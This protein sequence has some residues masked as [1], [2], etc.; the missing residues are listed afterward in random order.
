MTEDGGSPAAAAARVLLV[1]DDEKVRSSYARALR[2]FGCVVQTAT[3]GHEALA[4][5]GQTSF[6]LIITDIRMDGMAGT[7]LLRAVRERDLDVPVILMTGNPEVRTAVEAVEAGAFRYLT[8]P[9]DL[10]VLAQAVRSAIH[11]HVLAQVLAEQVP[12]LEACRRIVRATCVGLEWDV[13]AI[14]MPMA[15]G[16]R[17][18][19]EETW[20]RPGF[21]GRAFES[22]S[23]DKRIDLAHDLSRGR[24]DR[25]SPEWIADLSPDSS[26]PR[27]RAAR[28]AGFESALIVPF[29]ADGD[30]FATVEFF[31]SRRREPELT[32]L[33]LFA[34]SGARLGARVLR[35]RADQRAARAETKR[36]SVSNTLDAI[37]E[38]APALIMSIDTEGR[39]QFINRVLD[40]AKKEDAIGADWL[41]FMP[42][43]DEAV[44]RAHLARVLATGRAESY[45][46]RVA[47]PVGG[48]LWF[49][50]HM[51][52]LRNDDRVT[53]VVLVAQDVTELKRTQAEFVAAQRFVS[54]GTVAAGVAHEVNTP[55]QFVTDSIQFLRD[56]A[57]DTVGVLQTYQELGRLVTEGASSVEL[58]QAAAA[59]AASEEEADLSYL[60]ENV[61]KAFE[62]CLDGLGRISTI[63]RSMK[64][65]A[66]PAQREM[67]PADLN[68]ALQ[69]T[70]TI[71]RSEYK[72]VADLE[73]ELGELPLVTCHLNNINQV[74]LNLVVN[75]AH[76]IGDVVKGSGA[77]GTITVRTQRVGDDV[78]ISIRDTGGGI[79]P[80]IA[81]RIFE[82][83]F[84]T[85]GVGKGTGQ[86][87]AIARTIVKDGHGGQLT[88]ETCAGVGTT[89]FVRIP[90]LGKDAN[91]STPAAAEADVAVQPARA[92]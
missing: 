28:A 87:L 3:N 17:L 88:F 60:H 86:G 73:T 81:N 68:R 44:N 55:V 84:T 9:V 75:A 36:R 74:V 34:M 65:F 52:P 16:D 59:A 33:E 21:D 90:I 40:G 63:V 89:F 19:C 48:D 32:L 38:C 53:G 45:E 27:L 67:A 47:E 69:S 51:S 25:V 71:A 37:L 30:V 10:K 49:A 80:A 4:I 79:P 64:E 31:S 20:S 58:V 5:L 8:K 46:T 76:A 7:Q 1:D 41:R 72:Y 6:D 43:V 92:S 22:A 12:L 29:G 24:A 42:A 35:D 78:I 2:R 83:F 62:R 66:H 56:A 14:W 23:K 15:Q 13:A 82:P 39:I 85:K 91:A 61:P 70:F 18:Q 77:K 11:M 26:S 54:L 57:A 50:A